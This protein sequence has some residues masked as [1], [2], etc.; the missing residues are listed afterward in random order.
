L[1]HPNGF[2]ILDTGFPTQSSLIEG[3]KNPNRFGATATANIT[4]NT[5]IITPSVVSIERI[6]LVRSAV[7]AI[8]IFTPQPATALK[9][10]VI[11]QLPA[12]AI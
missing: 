3:R 7:I 9:R 6:K 5:P 10:L 11:R 4:E 1:T 12:G 8:A 2:F